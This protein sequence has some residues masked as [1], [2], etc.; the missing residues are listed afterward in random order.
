MT[1]WHRKVRILL[2]M[3]V[4]PHSLPPPPSLSVL[5]SPPP[6][7][8]PPPPLSVVTTASACGGQLWVRGGGFLKAETGCYGR[9]RAPLHLPRRCQWILGALCGLCQEDPGRVPQPHHHGG[10]GQRGGVRGWGQRGGVRGWSQGCCSTLLLLI[11]HR[12][13]CS[14][15]FIH[16]DSFC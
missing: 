4:L 5:S 14:Q 11:T 10:W 2:C 7:P 9:A 8:P 15:S 1:P 13:S 16:F 12:Y 3:C 6:P